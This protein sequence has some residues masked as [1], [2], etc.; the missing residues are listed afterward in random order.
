SDRPASASRRPARRRARSALESMK[1]T[2]ERSSTTGW[3]GSP[4]G[5][6]RHSVSCGALARSRSPPTLMTW[7]ASV[8][9]VLMLS[10][11]PAVVIARSSWMRVGPGTGSRRGYSGPAEPSWGRRPSDLPLEVLA[12]LGQGGAQDPRHMDLAHPDLLGDLGL[13]HPQVE[14]QVD[15]PTVP[16][17]ELLQRAQHGDALGGLHHR[18]VVGAGHA[19]LGCAVRTVSDD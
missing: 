7:P 19:D 2:A 12:E 6:A 16:L 11:S 9:S 3:D 4:P 1:D 14:A 10:P 18:R 15:D 8:S 5:S 13:G 17:G